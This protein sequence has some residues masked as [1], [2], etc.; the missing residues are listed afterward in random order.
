[1]DGTGLFGQIKDVMLPIVAPGIAATALLCFIFAWNEFF[2]AVQLNPVEGSTVPVWVSTNVTTR[3][4][5]IAMLSA[6]STLAVLPVVIAGL[7]AQKRM[8]R[9]LSMGAIK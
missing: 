2:L 7:I 5:F 6:E 8:I 1:M 3:G 9:G 4:Q